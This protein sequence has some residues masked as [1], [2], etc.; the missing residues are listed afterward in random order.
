MG[1]SA[2]V[3]GVTAVSGFIDLVAVDGHRFAAYQAEPGGAPRGRLVVIQEIMGVNRHIRNMCDRYA[4]AGYRALAPALF[5]RIERGIDLD[6]DILDE[7]EKAYEIYGALHPAR[8]DETMRDVEAAVDHLAADGKVGITG[9][10]YGGL[11]SWLAACR[12]GVDCA[13][14]YYGQITG[15]YLD[16]TPRCPTICHFGA[17]DAGIPSSVPAAIRERHAGVEVFVYDA[18][19]AF[20]NDD[21]AEFYDPV[22]AGEAH[23]RTLSLFAD[24]LG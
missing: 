20:N 22:A 5:D 12:V 17:R 19:H 24:H 16:E 4:Q 15:A 1:L 11:I 10:C 9:Y 7:R 21:A 23:E 18:N 13:S 8:L 6:Y 3:P 2:G 14:C